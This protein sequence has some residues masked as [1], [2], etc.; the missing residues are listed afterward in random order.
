M[1]TRTAV[2]VVTAAVA[3]PA[4]ALTPVVFPP[5]PLMAPTATHVPFFVVLAVIIA[6]ALWAGVAF[7]AY[8]LP[9]RAQAPHVRRS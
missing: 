1:R 3:V 6:H 8:G 4:L 7:L 2:A 5:S 9:R